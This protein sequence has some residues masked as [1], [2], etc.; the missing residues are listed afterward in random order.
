MFL[1][2]DVG[3]SRDKQERDPTGAEPECCDKG[4]GPEIVKSSGGWFGCMPRHAVAKP[5]Q[6]QPPWIIKNEKRPFCKAGKKKPVHC[7]TSFCVS[8][9]ARDCW[10]SCRRKWSHSVARDIIPTW[11]VPVIGPVA[12]RARPSS[13]AKRRPSSVRES[14]MKTRE[15]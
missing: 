1:S 6:N 13:M 14:V 4:G 7:S 3:N 9:S 2:A 11:R 12:K 8:Q 10:A 15:K 5:I